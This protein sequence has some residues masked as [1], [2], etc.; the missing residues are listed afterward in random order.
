[1]ARDGQRQKLIASDDVKPLVRRSVPGES[2]GRLLDG[3]ERQ[4]IEDVQRALLGRVEAELLVVGRIEQRAE[5][6]LVTTGHK[7][8]DPV[9]SARVVELLAGAGETAESRRKRSVMELLLQRRR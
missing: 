1:M 7:L 5:I 8:L 2:A 6:R 4:Q 9:K 3:L